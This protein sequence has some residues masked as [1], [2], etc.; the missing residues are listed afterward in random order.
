M[1]LVTEEE[2]APVPIA[3]EMEAED[4]DETLVVDKIGELTELEEDVAADVGI[5]L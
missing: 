1:L 2:D 4:A 5:R 3:D